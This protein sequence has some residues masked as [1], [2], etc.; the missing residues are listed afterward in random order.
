M[1]HV[2]VGLNL[3]K[4]QIENTWKSKEVQIS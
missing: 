2:V 4:L 3:K 1:P